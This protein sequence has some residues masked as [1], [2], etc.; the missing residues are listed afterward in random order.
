MFLVDVEDRNTLSAVERTYKV[1]LSSGKILRKRH[2][3][4]V[5]G[6]HLDRSAV[7][8]IELRGQEKPVFWAINPL[9]SERILGEWRDFCSIKGVFCVNNV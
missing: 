8:M 4:A 7:G 5:I 6:R 3:F 9:V 1:R 2:E